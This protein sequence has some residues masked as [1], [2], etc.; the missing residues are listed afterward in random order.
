ML[1]LEYN[2]H[3]LIYNGTFRRTLDL[4]SKWV[5]F[6]CDLL[7]VEL[8]DEG[9]LAKNIWR[10]VR[11]D[12]M[13]TKRMLIPLCTRGMPT[14]LLAKYHSNGIKRPVPSKKKIRKIPADAPK[15]AAS[16]PARMSHLLLM[17]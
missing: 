1:L 2:G 17:P 8:V 14:K 7:V 13:I 3:A 15:P 5:V 4:R 10:R 11:L 9:N 12:S 6:W 16:W